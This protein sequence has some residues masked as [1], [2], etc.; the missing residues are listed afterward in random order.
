MSRSRHRRARDFWLLRVV[1]GTTTATLAVAAGLLG[2]LAEDSRLLRTAVV[3]ALTGLV[4]LGL[5]MAAGAARGSQ[6]L[7]DATAELADAARELA[8]LRI[9]LCGPGA[10]RPNGTAGR[11]ASI[12]SASA[13]PNH[14]Y[15]ATGDRGNDRPVATGSRLPGSG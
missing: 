8:A 1:T 5:A 3:L 4:V 7:A 13:F 10:S 2:A 11:H 14:Q 15:P 6:Q 9:G 12:R